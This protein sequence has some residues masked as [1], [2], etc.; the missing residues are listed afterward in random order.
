MNR[1]SG[2]GSLVVLLRNSS[3]GASLVTVDRVGVISVLVD[4]IPSV[5]DAGNMSEQGQ[6]D[7]IKKKEKKNGR[8]LKK[9]WAF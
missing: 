3:V 1:L 8:P 4:G 5:N 9:M 7:A 6:S 2:G